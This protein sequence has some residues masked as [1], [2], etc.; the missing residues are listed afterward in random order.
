MKKY[1]VTYGSGQLAVSRVSKAIV[2]TDAK[3]LKVDRG[4]RTITAI[5]EVT[6]GHLFKKIANPASMTEVADD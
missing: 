2:G 3:L 6:D 1:T 4:T 5:I